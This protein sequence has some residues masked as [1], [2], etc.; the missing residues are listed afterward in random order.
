M[1]VSI[2]EKDKSIKPYTPRVIVLS[3]VPEMLLSN[4]SEINGTSH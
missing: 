4:I 3:C 2:C 1:F